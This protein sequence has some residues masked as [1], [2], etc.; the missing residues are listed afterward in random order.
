[1][2]ARAKKALLA[3]IP[4]YKC[5]IS[6]KMPDTVR[7]PRMVCVEDQLHIRRQLADIPAARLQL[8]GALS[9][10]SLLKRWIG[11]R[12][13]ALPLSTPF[14]YLVARDSLLSPDTLEQ[15]YAS[16]RLAGEFVSGRRLLK[17]RA[18]GRPFHDYARCRK[19]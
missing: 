12:A 11:A 16:I 9:F 3:A 2:V 14:V 4:D 17:G 8:A 7:V 19:D 6:N 18:A 5:E 13:A 1:M 10:Q 15:H